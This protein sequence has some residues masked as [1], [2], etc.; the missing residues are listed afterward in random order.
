[1]S[2]FSDISDILIQVG[3]C[4]SGNEEQHQ[5]SEEFCKAQNKKPEKLVLIKA[6]DRQL[7]VRYDDVLVRLKGVPR[8]Y[9]DNDDNSNPSKTENEKKEPFSIVKP[10]IKI[11]GKIEPVELD[12]LKQKDIQAK[13]SIEH[14]KE[15]INAAKK[16]EQEEKKQANAAKKREK[17]ELA[18]QQAKAAKRAEKEIAIQNHKKILNP[19]SKPLTKSQKAKIDKKVQTQ[20]KAVSEKKPPTFQSFIKK[21]KNERQVKLEYP[22]KVAYVRPNDAKFRHDDVLVKLPVS[23]FYP[24]DF[25]ISKQPLSAVQLDNESSVLKPNI[26]VVDKI[27]LD[28]LNM[29]TRPEKK[30]KRQLKREQKER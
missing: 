30:S 9:P 10:D 12:L 8:Y 1:M 11:V 3:L 29:K 14:L 5:T 15:Q 13:L 18:K 25:D 24:K 7:P 22:L 19:Q 23:R 17:T 6:K 27:E 26:K 2:I 16:Q 4:F 28:T 21:F 20:E